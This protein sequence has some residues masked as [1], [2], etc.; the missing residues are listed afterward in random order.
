MFDIPQLTAREL[1]ALHAKVAD[2]LIAREITRSYNNPTGDLAE[3]LFCKAFDWKRAGKA[4]ANID[5]VA[6][7]GTRYQ[8][9]GRRV[10][11]RNKSRQLGALR[12]LAGGHF[13]FLA[14]V[15][16]SEDYSITRA[17]IIPYAVA[18]ELAIFVKRTNSH[19]FLLRDDVWNAPSVRDVT[20]ELRAVIF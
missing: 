5:A 6:Q 11:Q 18:L 1:L 15:L 4:C 20:A 10:T 2:E 8:V 16:F 14:G 19:R 9:K 7:D 12:D 13:D 3:H 17:A